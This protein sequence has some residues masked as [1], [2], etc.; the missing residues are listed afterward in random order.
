MIR[1]RARGLLR[2]AREGET[3]YLSGRKA[4]PGIC[5]ASITRA[6][7]RR[8]LAPRAAAPRAAAPAAAATRGSARGS[9]P[10]VIR[11]PTVGEKVGGKPRGR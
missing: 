11:S 7:E 3:R 6:R 9:A 8:L 5:L 10:D 2:V 1:V 4:M